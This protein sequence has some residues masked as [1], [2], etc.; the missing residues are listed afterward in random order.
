MGAVASVVLLAAEGFDATVLPMG[1]GMAGAIFGGASLMGLVM[2]KSAILGYK[3]A[4]AGS[5]LGLLGL[6]AVL[7]TSFHFLGLSELTSVLLSTENIFGV[8]LFSGLLVYNTS[9]A[10]KR[11]EQGEADHLGMSIQLLI[12]LWNILLRIM[13]RMPNIKKK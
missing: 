9:L 13:A 11:Y 2:P 12:S 4:L 5:L 6:N 1:L 8:I 3:S 10:I 7:L